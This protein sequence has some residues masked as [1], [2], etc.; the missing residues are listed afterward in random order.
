MCGV[1]KNNLGFVTLQMVTSQV[2]IDL[3][4]IMFSTLQVVMRVPKA[5]EAEMLQAVASAKEAFQTWSQLSVLSR[6]QVMFRYQ[7]IIRR[8]MVNTKLC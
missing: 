1:I 3:S 5:T 7:D 8:N 2:P 4:I 6:Q